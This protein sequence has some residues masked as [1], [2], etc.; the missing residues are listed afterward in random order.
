MGYE[1][2]SLAMSRGGGD[3]Q[4]CLEW[5]YQQKDSIEI[6][7]YGKNL[8]A[9][10]DAIAEQQT[11]AKVISDY[12]RQVDRSLI[13][14]S[15]DEKAALE[16]AYHNLV[17]LSQKKLN[18]LHTMLE[19]CNMEDYCGNLSNEFDL[20]AVQLVRPDQRRK[21]IG[22]E[23]GDQIAGFVAPSSQD[24]IFA[25]KD[26]WSWLVRLV[27][28]IEIHLK[29]AADY[30]QFFHDADETE[31]FM[32]EDL[33]KLEKTFD[34]EPKNGDYNDAKR[35]IEELEGL[36]V[37]LRQWETKTTLQWDT[38]TRVLPVHMR[39]EGVSEPTPIRSLCEYQTRDI[40]IRE[41]EDLLLLD[42]TKTNTWKIRNNKGKEAFVPALICLIPG[43]YK[44][45]VDTA[46]KMRLKL[47]AAWTNC[48]KRIGKKLIVF[49]L[50]VFKPVYRQD[51]I[52]LLKSIKDM[53]RSE[54]L[55]ILDFIENS[56][57][58]HWSD[59]EAFINLQ[60]RILALKMILEDAAGDYPLQDEGVF[61]ALVVQITMLEKIMD[62]YKDLWKD[63]E[64]YK[65]ALE[66]SRAPE[67]MLMV[68]KWEQLQF[69]TKEYFTK[70]WQADLGLTP[71]EKK[72]TGITMTSKAGLN[73]MPQQ[74]LEQ[75]E[76]MVE[77]I[78]TRANVQYVE[79][80]ANHFGQ[81]NSDEWDS[82]DQDGVINSM[83]DGY[84]RAGS[85]SFNDSTDFGYATERKIAETEQIASVEM[86]EKKTFIISSV[87]DPRSN[88]DVSLQEAIM[89]G[90]IKP[91]EGIYC[92]PGS[93]ETCPIPVAMS[94]GW[95]KVSFSTTK[96]SRE[97]KSSIGIITVKTIREQ[98]RP[99]IIRKVKDTHTGEM[100]NHEEA[101]KRGLLDE[102]RGAYKDSRGRKRMTLTEAI[103]QGLV[104][105][106]YSQQ[107]SQPE[108]VTNSY[109]VRAVVDRRRKMIITFQ[110]AVQRGII[111]KDTGAYKDSAT[112]EV[113]YVGDAIMR[114][115]LKARQIDDPKSL[116][117]DPRNKLV[118]DKTETIKK[119][120]LKPLS[121][122][123][124]FRKAANSLGQ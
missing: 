50:T 7:K 103:E 40:H 111:L 99:F 31:I 90:I 24:C 60:E 96:R 21:M 26:N 113:M 98:V 25:A 57:K 33:K 106:E 38:A 56:L 86:E 12:R 16:T 77:E 9:V 91:E 87:L 71:E 49:M 84:T 30:H 17:E 63:W 104:D 102:A 72:M 36:L 23:T 15:K 69:V 109:A 123:S 47:M 82:V 112:G 122:I 68:D 117:I 124:A 20:K 53:E 76:F 73:I 62:K 114:G 95:I 1:A 37:A 22:Q 44:D 97:K 89:N 66:T 6:S 94:K 48:L 4:V 118:I 85:D 54:L 74:L 18:C 43:P 28:C 27:K 2:P 65:A 52:K 67:M 55:R 92:N 81:S 61:N 11:K 115:F 110:E 34:L 45:A 79:Q 93:G 83:E 64:V 100:V 58:V 107:V 75:A 121:V 88:V 42:N 35:L 14:V 80:N 51:E 46:V 29:N 116:D 41:G 8:R 78:D 70:F 59:N 3:Y 105:V 119:K 101:V 10:K 39:T 19:I 120:L 5:I 108:I 13:G 32:E